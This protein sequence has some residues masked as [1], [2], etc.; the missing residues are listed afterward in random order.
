ML[1]SFFKK[2]L[3]QFHPRFVRSIVYMLQ[4]S[5]Y[6]IGEYLTWLDRVT[7]F[8]RV[9]VRK[10][11][12]M[13]TKSKMLYAKMWG[14]IVLLC[15]GAVVGLM[16]ADAFLEYV[17]FG[18]LF[19]LAPIIAAYLI[20]IPVVFITYVIQKPYEWKM[21]RDARAKLALH[22]GFKIAIAGS[23]GKTT[24][25]QMLATVIGEGKRVATQE[26]NYNTLIGISR[27]IQSLKGDEDVI[28]FELGEYMPGDIAKMCRI[29]SPDLGIIT[30]VNE[31]HLQNFKSISETLRE[32]F[33][34]THF[35]RDKPLYVNGENERTRQFASHIAS[36]FLNAYSRAGIALAHVSGVNFNV[37]SAAT[38]LDGVH[39]II[40]CDDMP[41]SVQSKLLGLHQ[42]GPL[43]AAI[44][45][46]H[47]LGLSHEQIVSGVAKTSAFEHRLEPKYSTVGV[48]TL[49]DSYNGNPDG[50]MAVIDFLASL[51]GHRRFYVTPGLVEMGSA[52]ESVH[53]H[54]GQKLAKSGIENVVLI[55]NS[56]TP[57]IEFGLLENKYP[58]KIIKFTN[59]FAAFKA[60]E[61][62]TTTGDVVLLQNDWPDQYV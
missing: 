48:I 40:V 33:S 22:K 51:V 10:K 62:L 60:L 30:G 17:L 50:V 42:V 1:K 45:I 11:L 23:F 54:I 24:M 3:S 57:D 15:A 16:F 49:D 12:V 8:R 27:F 21:I 47:D 35:L 26:K 34:L 55:Q 5:E 2:F 31:A 41:I 46:A 13:T 37:T 36:P 59:A 14:I 32:I 18:L 25:R 29:I 9:E 56:A 7:D 6:H 52:T 53:R 61:H 4:S 28:I 19:L 44:K 20:I 38:D 58:G 43:S 39:F